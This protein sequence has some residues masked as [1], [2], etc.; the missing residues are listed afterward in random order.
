MCVP[1]VRRPCSGSNPDAPFQ[2]RREN[3]QTNMSLIMS[4]E[5]AHPLYV[6]LAFNMPV[7]ISGIEYLIKYITRDRG[8]VTI[9]L[10]CA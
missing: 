3:L 6:S 4:E 1:G 8:L 9:G 2:K 7:N 10:N 5:R